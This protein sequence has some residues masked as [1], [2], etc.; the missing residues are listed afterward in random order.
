MKNIFGPWLAQLRKPLGSVPKAIPLH[1][2][3]MSHHKYKEKVAAEF[4]AQYPNGLAGSNRHDTLKE[5]NRIA[6]DLLEKE[7]VA[8]REALKREARDDLEAAKQRYENARTGL[9]SDVPE[10]IEEYVGSSNLSSHN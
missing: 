8:V 3:Y 7:P 2:I 10:D 4:R 9:P 6:A 1:Q 5:R